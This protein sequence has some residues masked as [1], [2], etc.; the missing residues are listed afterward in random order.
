MRAIVCQLQAANMPEHVWMDF[1]F[2]LGFFRRT[3][4]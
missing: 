1:D 2:E 4:Q 3:F